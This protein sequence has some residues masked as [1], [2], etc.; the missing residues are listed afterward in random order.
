MAEVAI[1]K[2]GKWKI[3]NNETIVLSNVCYFFSCL[4]LIFDKENKKDSKV[5]T[6]H[7]KF[8]NKNL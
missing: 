5:W 3:T 7:L 6:F 2:L 4:T 1:L 8:F